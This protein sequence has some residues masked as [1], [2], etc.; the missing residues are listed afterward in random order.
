[1]EASF[2]HLINSRSGPSYVPGTI[3]GPGKTVIE[4]QVPFLGEIIL[5]LWKRKIV[6]KSI[7][8]DQ[9][10]LGAMKKSRWRGSY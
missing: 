6:L 10:V 2:I 1:M 3:L 8:E 5:P 9:V 4:D 7:I